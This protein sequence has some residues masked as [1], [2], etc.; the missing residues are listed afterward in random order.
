MDHLL[1]HA[2]CG[3]LSINEDGIIQVANQTLLNQLNCHAEQLHGQHMNSILTAP[4]RL[5]IQ[6]YFF[7]IIKLE[8]HVEEMYLSLQSS[9]GTEIP[10]LLNAKKRASA[11][12]CIIIPMLKRDIYENELLEAK[13]EAEAALQA[14][15]QANEEL[16]TALGNLKVKQ[17][18]LIKHKIATKKELELARKIQ[19]TSLTGRIINDQL[20][21]DAYYK[22]S[23]EL[24]GDIYGFYQMDDHRYGIIILDVMGH[25]LSSSLITMSLQSIFQRLISKG[26]TA[27][28][29][30]KELDNYLHNLFGNNEDTRH[31]C[32][33]IY[34][35][36]DTKNQEISYVNAGHPPAI[37]QDYEGNQ[38]QLRSTTLPIGS[39]EGLEFKINTIHYK[40]GGRLLLYTDGVSELFAPSFL[41]NFVLENKH[42]SLPRFKEK[43]IYSLN[44]SEFTY[45]KN[46]DQC[47]ILVDISERP[48]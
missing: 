37:W 23:S 8:S 31:Y 7:P 6:L 4:A 28:I 42:L 41:T 13:K 29:V 39:F 17:E 18:E 11:I 48:V 20:T 2:P 5:F 46:D 26:Y 15:K 10:V 35:V 27:D 21:I 47:F 16:K 3:F 36:V 14:K 1:N 19:E 30:M 9:N 25:G 45:R 33:A 38:H 43:M 34:L 12:D 44:N 22:A 24:S 40:T 32:T